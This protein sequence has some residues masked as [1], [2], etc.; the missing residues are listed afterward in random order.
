M[1]SRWTG[2]TCTSTPI[3]FF[4]CH[5]F[6][7]LFCA[8]PT[9]PSHSTVPSFCLP[10]RDLVQHL[11]VLVLSFAN[12]SSVFPLSYA[13]FSFVLDLWWPLA[14]DK[15]FLL[16]CLLCFFEGLSWSSAIILSYSRPVPDVFMSVSVSNV[17]IRALCPMY[18]I[19]PLFFIIYIYIIII[20]ISTD[21][22]FIVIIIYILG[23]NTPFN[24]LIMIS[25]PLFFHYGQIHLNC[26]KGFS[27]INQVL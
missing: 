16:I 3:L 4:S 27:F 2:H 15:F 13:S 23:K 26:G 11:A 22:L 9:L 20:F 14:V 8:W 7:I 12:H 10:L 19:A 17:A 6:P 18:W 5:F 25:K 21:I 24:S 1:W